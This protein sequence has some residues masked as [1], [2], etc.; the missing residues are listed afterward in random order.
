MNM[1]HDGRGSNQYEQMKSNSVLYACND[2][3]IQLP[4]GI[5]V[6]H[7]KTIERSE[8]SD[9]RIM[10]TTITLKSSK[11]HEYLKTFVQKQLDAYIELKYKE[12][13]TNDQLHFYTL[14][15]QSSLSSLKNGLG[16][17]GNCKTLLNW[18]RY[19]LNANRTFDSLFFDQ[20]KDVLSLIENFQNKT[21]MFAFD[22]VP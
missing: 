15:V 7:E 11:P 12:F 22:S 2:K 16:S 13:D 18:R 8:A 19:D 5:T 17:E 20:K 21:G 14:D 10:K 4:N 3:I 1:E 6:S 9:S